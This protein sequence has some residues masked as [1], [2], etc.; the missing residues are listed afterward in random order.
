LKYI[1]S[2][3]PIRESLGPSDNTSVKGTLRDDRAMKGK[4]TEL[5]WPFQMKCCRGSHTLHIPYK[6]KYQR[7]WIKWKE[8]DKDVRPD[9]CVRR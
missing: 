9:R 6:L 2:R 7:S 3:K 4:F 1:K 5:C 8:I